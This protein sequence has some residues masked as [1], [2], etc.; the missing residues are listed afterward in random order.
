MTGPLPEPVE[1]L[2]DIE[3]ERR[4]DPL[5]ESHSHVALANP[6]ELSDEDA[7]SLVRE[8]AAI[9]RARVRTLGPFKSE[10]DRLKNEVI[11][12]SESYDK[13]IERFSGA[14]ECYLE[15]N[16]PE[17][18]KSVTFPAGVIGTR[19]SSGSI[20]V[21]DVSAAVSWCRGNLPGAIRV[22]EKVQKK[23]LKDHLKRTGE[24]PDGIEY[25]APEDR[26]YV[27]PN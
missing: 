11:N 22:E 9:E 12:I 7:S 6:D 15:N 18:G 17:R 8:I 2:L 1:V 23:V 26:F 10:I 27:K 24:I 14:L 4:V 21:L 25:L 19:R 5:L 16:P 20:D 3:E 13:Q